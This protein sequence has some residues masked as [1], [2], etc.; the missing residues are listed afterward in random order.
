MFQSMN[1]PGFLFIDTYRNVHWPSAAAR[2]PSGNM[3]RAVVSFLDDCK[4]NDDQKKNTQERV[5]ELT[6][7]SASSELVL[8]FV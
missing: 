1:V 8:G 7:G 6:D 2:E 3:S 4:E 5:D